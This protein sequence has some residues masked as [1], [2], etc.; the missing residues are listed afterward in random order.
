MLQKYVRPFKW[1]RSPR[2]EMLNNIV[3]ILG[4]FPQSFLLPDLQ[5]SPLSAQSNATHHHLPRKLS[6]FQ[7]FSIISPFLWREH[8]KICHIFFYLLLLPFDTPIYTVS[9]LQLLCLPCLL[10]I[11]QHLATKCITGK[12]MIRVLLRFINLI[13]S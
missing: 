5:C 12:Y 2:G 8:L 3:Q 6:Y 1:S 10:K 11:S 9:S 4:I 7:H 13:I